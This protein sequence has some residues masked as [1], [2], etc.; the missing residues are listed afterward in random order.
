MELFSES[1]RSAVQG[2]FKYMSARDRETVV[3]LVFPVEKPEEK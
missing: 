1:E 3:D 2:L